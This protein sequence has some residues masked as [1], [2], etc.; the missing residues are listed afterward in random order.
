M[1]SGQRLSKLKDRSGLPMT[2]RHLLNG[3]L[4]SAP[5]VEG[6]YELCSGY[7]HLSSQHFQY[8]LAR[9]Q[10]R[11]DGK[12]EFAIGDDDDHVPEE[13]KRR[14]VK[15]FVATTRAVPELVH[16]WCELRESHGSNSQ[17]K[18]RFPRD[19]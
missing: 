19:V 15:A 18:T 14:L 7:V 3:L 6:V 10:T 4:P 2:D 13:G 9:C 8:F 5:W 17:L 1:F 16:A 12:R 11:A